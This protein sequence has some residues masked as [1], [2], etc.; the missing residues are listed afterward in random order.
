MKKYEEIELL[1]IKA[2]REKEKEILSSLKVFKSEILKL[3]KD[4][5]LEITD[6][7][8]EKVADK[9]KKEMEK[10]LVIVE[11]SK[12]RLLHTIVSKYT[13]QKTTELELLNWLKDKF[14]NKGELMKQAKEEFGNKLDGKLLNSLIK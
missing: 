7:L 11:D 1:I 14:G 4:S 5:K 3:S 13:I 12:N 8:V 10:S 9:L 2:M 6:D